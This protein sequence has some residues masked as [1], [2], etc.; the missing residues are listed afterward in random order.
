[1]MKFLGKIRLLL[2]GKRKGKGTV[3]AFTEKMNQQPRYQASQVGMEAG[4]KTFRERLAGL[5]RERPRHAPVRSARGGERGGG[6]RLLFF[7]LVLT[8]ILLGGVLLLTGPS[9]GFL[10]NYRYFQIRNIEISGCRV[11]TPTMLRKFAGINYQMNMLT[12]DPEAIQQ[13]L[14]THPWVSLAKIRRIWPNELVVS[15]NEYRPEAL[16]VQGKEKGLYYLDQ[17]GKIFAPVV[18]GMALDFPVV[19]GLDSVEES[20]EKEQ[21]LIQAVSF[22]RLAQINNPNLPAQNV[23]E[24]HLTGEGEMI[25]YLVKHPFPIYFGKGDIKRKYYQLCKVLEVLYQKKKDGALIEK[26]AFIRMDYLENKVLVA[27]SSAG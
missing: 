15:I 22:L 20:E 21:V 25:L 8:V 9:R 27:Q 26:V 18:Q 17:S 13:L 2:A 6:G 23:S 24:I 5:V 1:M 10:E 3:S 11:T 14:E 7:S 19:T 16:I 4:K 12:L